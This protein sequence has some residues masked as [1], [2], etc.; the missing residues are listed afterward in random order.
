MEILDFNNHPL[1]IEIHTDHQKISKP[2][3]YAEA[4][5]FCDTLEI[6]ENTDKDMGAEVLLNNRG[7]NSLVVEEDEAPVESLNK[8]PEEGNWV[9]EDVVPLHAQTQTVTLDK[10]M[11]TTIWV[12][13]NQEHQD[14]TSTDDD[15]MSIIQEESI[16]D[17]E[18]HVELENR[19]VGALNI[20]EA[21]PLNSTELPETIEP[22]PNPSV[23]LWVRQNILALGK[24]FGVNFHGYEKLAEE[25][26]MKIDGKR[27]NLVEAT[28]TS[29]P[30]TPKLK[31]AKELKNLE[32]G[33]KFFSYGSRSR[34]ECN[35]DRSHED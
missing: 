17:T 21:I 12:H 33:T 30:E 18:E 11:D 13:V 10:E 2:L 27:N 1:Q 4:V 15:A 25:L 22:P 16:F 9:V 31:G 5:G 32:S 8:I 29:I 35:I 7:E 26:F 3:K 24:D 19:E 23:Q 14:T 34:G 6:A 28:K 20:E